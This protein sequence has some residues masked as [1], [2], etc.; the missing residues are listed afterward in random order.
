M[1]AEEFRD[2]IAGTPD[3][4]LYRYLGIGA[5]T[6][7]RYKTGG[8]PI[9]IPVEKLLRLRL[10]DL[11]VLGGR[12]WEGFRFGVD[13]LFYHPFWKKGFTPEELRGLF[14]TVQASWIDRRELGR[15]RAELEELKAKI[16]PIEAFR[17]TA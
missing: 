5:S 2:L 4:M 9:P 10:G 12:D 16:H 8:A 1:K 15:V 6:F 13:G 11:S 14:F 3:N 17:L 7:R